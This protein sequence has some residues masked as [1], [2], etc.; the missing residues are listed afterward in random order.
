MKRLIGVLV[1]TAAAVVP[2]MKFDV[3]AQS[4]APKPAAPS[5][6]WPTYGH[7][8]GGMRFSPAHADHASQ[9]WP[10]AGGVGVP[11]A[12]GSECSRR[13]A[14][15]AAGPGTGTRTR[16]RRLG[17]R[18][19][20][21]HAARRQRRDVH[22]DALRPRRRARP[23]DGQRGLGLSGAGGQPLDARRRVLARRC[24]NAAADRLRHRRR[25]ALLA[26]RKDRP[27]NRDLRRPRQ[28]RH[29]HARDPAG[30]V[31]KRRPQL[32][33][34]RLQE[35]H[36]HGRP[37]PGE[38]A[39]R[40]GGRCACLGRPHRQAGVD[41]PVGAAGGRE[42]QRHL[43]GRQLEEPLGRQRLGLH[44]RR[45]PARH[46][47]HAVRRAVGRSIR[48]RPRRRQPLRHEHRRGRR[49][50]RQVPLALPGRA[51]R[52]LG[53]RSLGGAGADRRQAGWQ[54][55][56]GRGGDQQARAAVPARSRD[57][58]ADLRRRGASGAAERGAARTPVE[59]A[60]V[61]A[62][63]AA[64]LAHDDDAGRYRDRDARARSRVPEAHGGRADSAAPTC[65]RATSGCACSFRAITAA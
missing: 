30:H 44:H 47:L 7:D 57:R 60:A 49:E 1:V 36:H 23:D 55:D 31:R 32:A 9:C 56:S 33:A 19:E 38:S 27:A 10:A 2:L 64:A 5:T 8:P 46:R 51:P 39:Q 22:R 54:D 41:V 35:P 58:Q 45:R 18:R 53:R 12:S 6:E 34:D 29:E 62:Q 21:D 14:M 40:A 42:V 52:H 15:P 24:A 43:G 65:R 48:R 13:L 50:H 3:R 17:L 25:P 37:Q 4:N 63:A 20:R 11:H 26:R 28:H 16:T 61:P 59:D